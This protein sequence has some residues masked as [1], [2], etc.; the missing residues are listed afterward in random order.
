[1]GIFSVLGIGASGLTAYQQAL[2]VTSQNIVNSGNPDYS[3][4]TAELTT[5]TPQQRDGLIWGTG[6]QVGDIT[7]AYDALTV[8]QL[9]NYNS[10]YS[11]SNNTNILLSQVQ[12]LLNEPSNQGISELTTAFFNSWQQLSVTPNSVALRQNVVQAAQSLSNQIQ[13]INQGLDSIQTNIKG[14]INSDVNT[15]NKDLQQIQSLNDQIY[16]LQ[17]VGQTPNDLLDARDK[18]I[19]DLSNLV[20]INVNYDSSNIA[21]VSIGGV[22]AADQAHA[23]QFKSSI[24]NGKV[25]LTNQDGSATVNINGGKLFAET[26]VYN[27]TIPSYQNSI[28]TFVNNLM[29]SVNTLHSGGYT[30]DN[31][32]QTGI[33]FFEG[34]SDGVLKINSAI[35]NDP[36]KIAVS[37][38][39]T[40][41]NGDIALSLAALSTTKQADG[42][43]LLDDYSTFVSQVGTDVK[44]A[45]D[46]ANSY[47]LAV[48]QLQQQKSSISG[49][50][51]DEEMTNVIQYQ[52]SYT[53]SAKL[54]TVADQMLQTLIDMVS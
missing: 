3:R 8:Q 12:S 46:N 14:G 7:R 44:G 11:N 20:N 6:V 38:D 40:S 37:S 32:P 16:N 28:N 27:N 53:A 5:T 9:R 43:T 1:M 35:V 36:N 49:V 30:L 47:N 15:I 26:N 42:N 13:S 34:Y 54:I 10:K 31:P 22:L 51:I 4:Q 23:V 50:S 41:G 19:S 24:Q 48:Q 45:S 17:S 25:V 18:V 29:Q 39:G 21:D 52:K 33:N 2:D